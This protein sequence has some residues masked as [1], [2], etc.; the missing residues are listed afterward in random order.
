MDYLMG[1]DIGTTAVK[2]L[3][4]DSIGNIMVKSN[5][6]YGLLLPYPG[7]VEQDAESMWQSV[8]SAVK[9]AL[10]NFIGERSEIRAISLSTQRDTLVCVDKDNAP[11]RNTITWMDSRSGAQ[12]AGL[13]RDIGADRVYGITGVGISTIWT[14]A[15]ILWL[16]ENEPENFRK[17][18]CFGLVHDFILCRLGAKGHY[19]DTS[20][21]C[22]TML[23]DLGRGVWSPELMEYGGL[24][25]QKLPVLVPPGTE[26][27]VLSAGLAAELGLPDTTILVSGGGDQQCASLGAGAVCEGDVEIGI[28]TAANILASV[29]KPVLDRRRRLICH[30]AA[31]RE[32]WVL[33][34]AMLA[35][36][37]VVEWVRDTFYNGLSLRDI[38]RDIV[39]NSAPGAGGLVVLPHFEGAGCPYWNPAAKGLI[40]GLTLSSDRA[41]IARALYESIAFE[42]RKNLELLPELGITPKKIII[43]GGAS[44]SAVW[45]QM[46]ADVTGMTVCIPA[47]TDCAAVGAAVLAGVGCGLF[48]NEELAVKKIVSVGR[49]YIP[50]REIKSLYDGIYRK[51][52]ALYRATDESRL[53]Q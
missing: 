45:M 26:V 28:G 23:F 4:I 17:T 11:V 40:Y 18:V 38:D 8:I 2:V 10:D 19:L 27:G 35:T 31:V 48:E 29:R 53:Y 44:R 6:E 9:S 3:I 15:F 37:K 30:R 43:S 51:N 42:I 12:C 34:G 50:N 25:E 39:E 41:G 33:E 5:V 52:K 1:I 16:R 49:E 7:W 32:L 13:E 22:Q 24:T 14:F 46:T 36:G 20:N 21:A 47:E